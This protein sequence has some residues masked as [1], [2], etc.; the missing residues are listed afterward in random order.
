MRVL[1]ITKKQHW[2]GGEIPTS[3]LYNSIVFLVSMLSQAGIISKHAIVIDNNDIDREVT[4]FQP[5]HVVI[6]ALWVVPD[7]FGVLTSLH[8][9]VRWV[10]RIHSKLPFLS[11]EGMALKWLMAYLNYP[12]L[13]VGFNSRTVLEDFIFVLQLK[14]GPSVQDLFLYMPNY[15]G[16]NNQGFTYTSD[17]KPKEK[18]FLNVGC[19]GA[20]R[21]LKNQLN[22]AVA[23]LRA[24]D[25][26]NLILKFH[27]NTGRVEGY[28]AEA[29]LKNLRSLFESLQYHKLVEHPWLER[30]AFLRLLASMDVNLQVSF[31]ETYNI[32]A[33]DSVN[34]KV[35]VVASEEVE[36]LPR[37]SYA[38]PNSTEDIA[39]RI[40]RILGN[41]RQN[42]ERNLSAL[43]AYDISS[44][45]V[46]LGWVGK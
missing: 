44:K 1:F 26:M 2:Y 25:Q 31:S 37:T 8:P 10:V 12:N 46:W 35:P 24:A 16:V 36:W 33:A 34:Q 43:K 21:S 41:Y 13:C 4:K 7:K 29:I 39:D 3:G 9:S 5:T 28:T 15:Y 23:A 30:N 22:Q 40:I 14:Y 11:N 32:V 38:D 19:F 42:I 18:Y 45:S 17:F 20:I 6:E 27:I